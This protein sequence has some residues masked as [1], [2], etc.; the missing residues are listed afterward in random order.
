VKIGV[1]KQTAPKETR[2]ALVPAVV[3]KLVVLGHEVLVEPGAGQGSFYSDEDYEKAGA[4]IW[5]QSS[6]SPSLWDQAQ[7]IV[8]IHPPTL[9]QVSQMRNQTVLIGLLAPVSHID[10]VVTYATR[11]ITS[12]SMEFLPRISRAQPMDVLSSQANIAGYMAAVLGAASCPKMYPMMITAAGTIAPA[13]VLIIGA[14]VAGLQ[15][16][17]TAKRLGAMVE[18]YD[19]RPA[20]REQVQSLG[21]RFVDLEMTQDDAQTAGGYAKAMSEDQLREQVKRLSDHVVRADVVITTAAIFGKAPPLLIPKAT[22]KEMSAGSV[23]IDLAGDPGIG[24][25][26]CESTKPDK[27]ITTRNGVIIEGSSNLATLAPVHSS[28]MYANNMFAFLKEVLSDDGGLKINLEDEI[29]KGTLI[30]H[31][32]DVL[33]EAVVSRLKAGQAS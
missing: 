18:A 26:N 28:Q 3:K 31:G 2:A 12:F 19:V 5:S 1:P 21:A 14:G 7:V 33:Q 15:A 9:E 16:I 24:R 6:G 11:E 22:V 27:R 8:T 23:I 17:A 10:R 20:V 4:T 13:K 30:T 25:G 29:Q 32:G